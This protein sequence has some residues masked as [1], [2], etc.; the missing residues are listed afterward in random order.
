MAPLSARI[1]IVLSAVLGD[2][3]AGSAAPATQH[4]ASPGNCASARGA[5]SNGRSP[6]Q[7]RRRGLFSKDIGARSRKTA[8]FLRDVGA[9][10]GVWPLCDL[11]H[12]TVRPEG[13]RWDRTQLIWNSWVAPKKREFRPQQFLLNLGRDQGRTKTGPIN[14]QQSE[15]QMPRWFRTPC[16]RGQRSSPC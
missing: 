2:H 7:T 4:Q 14:L 16:V 15:S 8:S 9:L 5:S 11:A 6:C 10:R 12:I 1:V 13:R 3:D